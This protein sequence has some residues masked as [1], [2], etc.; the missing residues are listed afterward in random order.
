MQQ[1][2]DAYSSSPSAAPHILSEEVASCS[3]SPQQVSPTQHIDLH[4][5]WPVHDVP[6][7]STMKSSFTLPACVFCTIA[8]APGGK[9]EPPEPLLGAGTGS[10]L[11]IVIPILAGVWLNHCLCKPHI[12]TSISVA[13][14]KYL[15]QD[16]HAKHICRGLWHAHVP[17]SPQGLTWLN[18]PS[19]SAW[20]QYIA[21]SGR[22]RVCLR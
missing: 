4:Q 12:I 13:L 9:S 1:Q 19:Q 16:V 22:R 20:Q 10:A 5:V 2:E 6:S 21:L 18:A 14:C 7:Q 8:A 11:L 17:V 3:R 15:Y